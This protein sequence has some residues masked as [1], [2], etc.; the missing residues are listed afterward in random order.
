MET[1]HKNRLKH[2]EYLP[3][4]IC[5][6]PHCKMRGVILPCLYLTMSITS[7][8]WLEKACHQSS[9]QS[10]WDTCQLH[11]LN[12][13][14]KEDR[15]NSSESTEW[16]HTGT[17]SWSGTENKDNCLKP[18][19]RRQLKPSWVSSKVLP[20]MQNAWSSRPR[21]PYTQTRFSQW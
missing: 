6:P 1:C 12:S 8:R 15:T 17:L 19:S 21:Y 10:S 7:K 20:P 9:S 16:T 2:L 14:L 18:G 11:S 3:K 4:L 5:E 13:C